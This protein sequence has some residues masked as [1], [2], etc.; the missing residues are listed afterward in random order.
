MWQCDW[1]SI[2]KI[3]ANI[4][5]KYWKWIKQ[6]SMFLFKQVSVYYLI[7]AHS[8]NNEHISKYT[9]WS[10]QVF[11][12]LE[13][14]NWR[15]LCPEQVFLGLL[16]VSPGGGGD[17]D[18]A[19]PPVPRLLHLPRPRHLRQL[20]LHDPPCLLLRPQLLVTAPPGA[21]HVEILGH[22]GQVLALSILA[23]M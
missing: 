22:L 12:L 9:I 7:L 5:Y 13:L 16:L 14:H 20:R 18:G 11:Q 2:L 4:K 8:M 6:I 23:S 15:R 17:G 10:Q 3:Y 19:A 1:L 21:A